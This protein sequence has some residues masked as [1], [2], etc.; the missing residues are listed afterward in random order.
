MIEGL[1]LVLSNPICRCPLSLKRDPYS[2]NVTINGTGTLLAI[3]VCNGCSIKMSK[4]LNLSTMVLN[5]DVP[6][7]KNVEAAVHNRLGLLL[8]G[9]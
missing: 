3:I 5:A 6:A 7:V 1:Y 4:P 8:D 2:C 9:K